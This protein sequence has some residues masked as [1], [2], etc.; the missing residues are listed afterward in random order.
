MSRE[1]LLCV[2]LLCSAAVLMAADRVEIDERTAIEEGRV[3]HLAA[4]LWGEVLAL[5][6][7][8]VT[9][10]FADLG[11]DSLKAI[12]LL[13]RVFQDCGVEVPLQSLFPNGNIKTVAATIDATGG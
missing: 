8:S 11:G 5:N 10:G 1:G 6:K 2:V 9:H 7:V 12:R 3:V 4:S 13:S